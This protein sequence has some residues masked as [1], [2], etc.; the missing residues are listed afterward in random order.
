[1]TN[2]FFENN[3][4]KYLRRLV[5]TAT[6]F[7]HHMDARQHIIAEGIAEQVQ[8]FGMEQQDRQWILTGWD[9]W[10]RNPF[11]RGEE[12]QH[13]EDNSTHEE[14]LEHQA[15]LASLKAKTWAGAIAQHA[16]GDDD[17]PF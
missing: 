1:M 7:A 13:P 10:E 12:Q 5:F 11:Y 15:Y 17:C 3:Q 6:L 8:I 4:R 16:K 14:W 2:F 9:T